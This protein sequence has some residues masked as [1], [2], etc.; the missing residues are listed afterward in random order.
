MEDKFADLRKRLDEDA[1]RSKVKL[2]MIV[3]FDYLC[4]REYGHNYVSNKMVADV[5]ECMFPDSLNSRDKEEKLS[6]K[7]YYD[8]LKEAKKALR[9]VF[10]EKY[11]EDNAF[12]TRGNKIAYHSDEDN[13]VALYKNKL[14]RQVKGEMEKI[15]IMSKDLFPPAWQTSFVDYIYATQGESEL[16]RRKV[17]DFGTNLLLAHMDLIPRLYSAIVGYEVLKIEFNMEY[18]EMVTLYIAPTLLKR[19]NDRWHVAGYETDEQGSALSYNVWALD[20]IKNIET[21]KGVKCREQ[22]ENPQDNYFDDIVGIRKPEGRKKEK[23]M[24]HSTKLKVDKLLET[25]PIHPSQRRVKEF[26]EG[27]QEGEFEIEVIPNTELMTRLFSYADGLY[28]AGEGDFQNE[29]KGV[30]KE[31]AK[32]Y[33]LSV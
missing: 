28:V 14:R 23:L 7:S 8:S 17:I 24:L 26:V 32:R 15:I 18:R 6:N 25:K 2:K 33:S 9:E 30:I 16:P 11:G 22:S 27:I 13:G 31:L 20:R 29:L 4:H 10:D 12:L 1:P 19:Y 21:V 3:I 5:Y